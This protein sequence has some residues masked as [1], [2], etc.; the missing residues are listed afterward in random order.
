M[1]KD[2]NSWINKLY[3]QFNGKHGAQDVAVSRDDADEETQTQ[4]DG[5]DGE[6]ILQ[7]NVQKRPKKMHFSSC[8]CSFSG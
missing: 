3:Q 2:E 7:I 5:S 6:I 1:D 8:F 4:D